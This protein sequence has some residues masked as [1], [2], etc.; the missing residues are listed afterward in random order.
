MTWDDFQK[1]RDNQ[2]GGAFISLKDGEFVEGVFAGSPKMFYQVYKDPVEYSEWAKGR[3]FKFKINFIVK[4]EAGNLKAKI[5]KGGSEMRNQLLDCKKEYGL[6]CVF[7]IK[8][9]GAGKEDTRYSILFKSQLTN[10]QKKAIA[11]V[12]LIS[13]DESNQKKGEAPLYED[14]IPPITDDDMPF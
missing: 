12:K 6:D 8:R 7:K 10:E 3:S 5:F 11:E 13:F 14:D 4:D 9:T 1:S 2:G